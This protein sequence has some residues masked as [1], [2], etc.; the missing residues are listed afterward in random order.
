MSFFFHIFSWSEYC[1]SIV[2]ILMIV[3][4]LTREFGDIKGW[5][6]LFRD[7]YFK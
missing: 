2:F 5:D 6:I 3:L 4:W 1:V 7:E